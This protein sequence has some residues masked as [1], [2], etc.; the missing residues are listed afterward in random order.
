MVCKQCNKRIKKDTPVCPYCGAPQ[1]ETVSLG[2]MHEAG[3]KKEKK[4]MSGKKKLILTL[5]CVAAV[6][7]AAGAAMLWLVGKP[8]SPF[9]LDV[10]ERVAR[11]GAVVLLGL[12]GSLLAA[13]L[14]LTCR[15]WKRILL[16]IFGALFLLAS[17]AAGCGLLFW[18]DWAGDFIDDN[19]SHG[20]Q[21]N[22]EDLGINEVL[23]KTGVL[24]IALFG[25]DNRTDSDD[26]RSD[27]IIVLSVDRDHNK[28]KLTSIAR[29]TLANVKDYGWNNE[30]R[31]DDWTKLTHAFA[32]GARSTD[33]TKSGPSVAV[34]AL[35]ENFN[36][37]ITKY[38]YVNFHEFAKI[39][40]LI[41]G[42]EIEV[43]WRELAYMNKH[44][45]SMNRTTGMSISQLR[46]AG[47]QT[48]T[49]G[50]ALAYARL[51]HVDSDIKRGNRQKAVIDAVLKKA[52][53]MSV[54]DYPDLI[55]EALGIC[56]TN[57][58]GQEI[59][60]IA[61]W[62]VNNNPETVNFSLPDDECKLYTWDSYSNKGSAVYQRHGSVYVMDL[63]Y[64]STYLHDFIYETNYAKPEYAQKVTQPALPTGKYLNMPQEE[65]EPTDTDT[66]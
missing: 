8:L 30:S 49:G 18:R 28:I 50:Q 65:T 35:N 48:L 64:V 38:A 29:D 66:P 41:G 53:E 10:M 58:T 40:D 57:L 9:N 15:W 39:I 34:R 42:V 26:G 45:Q 6:L 11:F 12:G 4:R 23:P 22:E 21:L 1:T 25:L 60:E 31:D 17:L 56:N 33:E 32:Y 2:A 14:M 3:K 55:Q 16:I 19:V 43:E 59:L 24:N 54:L 62:L 5:I 37:N 61:E 47:K 46:T 36:L 44:I 51:R 13:G 7:L 20:P 52:R 27:A 63:E